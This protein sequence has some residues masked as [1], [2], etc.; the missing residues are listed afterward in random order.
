[1]DI[2]DKMYAAI[3]QGDMDALAALFAPGARIW[4]NVDETEKSIEEASGPLLH[5]YNSATRIDYRDRRLAVD[6]DLL[7]VQHAICA[8]L[9]SGGEIRLPG[10]MRIQLAD[11]GRIAR[12]EEYFDSRA[13][14]P[15]MAA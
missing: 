11:D 13:L 1:M 10:M 3:E 6:G 15:L 5:L 8:P 4:H 9:K 14:D 7:F 2:I 12:I